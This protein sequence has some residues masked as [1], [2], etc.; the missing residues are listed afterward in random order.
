MP[1]VTSA[2]EK[3]NIKNNYLFVLRH[4][5]EKLVNVSEQLDGECRQNNTE[6]LN[7]TSLKKIYRMACP[8]NRLSNC[9]N[10]TDLKNSMNSVYDQT[11]GLIKPCLTDKQKKCHQG[12]DACQRSNSAVLCRIK[13]SISK[14]K[15]CWMQFL[16]S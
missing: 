10:S 9:V 13:K 16:K 6:E 7:C 11:L 2:C 1:D 12:T 8:L 15:L 5:L 14:Y 3:T 4:H